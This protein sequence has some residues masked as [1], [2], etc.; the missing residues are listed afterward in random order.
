MNQLNPNRGPG[1]AP[2]SWPRQRA[3]RHFVLRTTSA[4]RHQLTPRAFRE[5][6]SAARAGDG[7]SDWTAL[8]STM[9]GLRRGDSRHCCRHWAKSADDIDAEARCDCAAR[10]RNAKGIRGA[11]FTLLFRDVSLSSGL[12][13]WTVAQ[14]GS[15]GSR[16]LKRPTRCAWRRCTSSA[17]RMTIWKAA[18]ASQLSSPWRCSIRS[19]SG[20]SHVR[21]LW[22]MANQRAAFARACCMAESRGCIAGSFRRLS[23]CRSHPLSLTRRASTAMA[24]SR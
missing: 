16:G 5:L 2:R 14:L 4:D 11:W 21:W 3:S 1:R 12:L 8:A 22:G 15:T 23:A 7:A 10:F 17:R 18:K 19:Y 24:N 6:L 20:T 13:D 9:Y